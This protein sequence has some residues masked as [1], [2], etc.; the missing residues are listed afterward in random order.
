MNKNQTATARTIAEIQLVS[1]AARGTLAVWD[2]NGGGARSAA[3]R[4][5]RAEHAAE[6][7]AALLDAIEGA[8]YHVTDALEK[9][10]DWDTTAALVDTMHQQLKDAA[11]LAYGAAGGAKTGKAVQAAARARE[12]VQRAGT[13][14][15]ELRA[16]I[17]EAGTAVA[18]E[19]REGEGLK[20]EGTTVKIS[21]I[22][23]AQLLE[24]LNLMQRTYGGTWE[25]EEETETD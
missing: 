5:E 8:R 25:T 21:G 6:L 20:A 24:A 15:L 18:A 2:Y 22:S 9:G 1:N 3:K 4:A 23:R 13:A 12:I 16:E 19:H 7:A 11:R 10:H 14:V 17:A